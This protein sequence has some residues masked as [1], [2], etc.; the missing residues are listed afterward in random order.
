M[1]TIKHNKAY[2]VYT[3]AEDWG[4]LRK[5]KTIA[6]FEANVMKSQ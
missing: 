4:L 5:T 3:A 6:S 1:Q 2:V